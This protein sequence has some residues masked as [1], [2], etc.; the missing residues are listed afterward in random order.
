MS[1]HHETIT[2]AVTIKHLNLYLGQISKTISFHKDGCQVE[3]IKPINIYAMSQA[4][5]STR[6]NIIFYSTL[7]TRMLWFTSTGSVMEKHFC[8]ADL[9][10]VHQQYIPFGSQLAYIYIYIYIYTHIYNYYHS[11]GFIIMIISVAYRYRKSISIIELF[12]S[13]ISIYIEFL[14]TNF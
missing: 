1:N 11:W 2:K 6:Y 13:I 9:S 5:K 8:W 14:A 10:E 12:V 3:N 4:D 7:V